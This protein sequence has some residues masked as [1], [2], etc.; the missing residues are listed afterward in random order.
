MSNLWMCWIG[1]TK[2]IPIAHRGLVHKVIDARISWPRPVFCLM[3]KF[4]GSKT[5]NSQYTGRNTSTCRSSVSTCSNNFLRRCVSIC[6]LFPLQGTLAE[7]L[8]V[9]LS[10]PYLHRMLQKQLPKSSQQR[11]TNHT[12]CLCQFI[13]LFLEDYFSCLCR[14]TMVKDLRFVLHHHLNV[15]VTKETLRT[16]REKLALMSE[17]FSFVSSWP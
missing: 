13:E 10:S 5:R 11:H 9:M 7:R 14:P 2:Y 4:D 12:F 16:Y 17:E 3:R 15:L 8:C 6:S 1:L